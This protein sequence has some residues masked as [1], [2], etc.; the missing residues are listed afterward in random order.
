M[1]GVCLVVC[2]VVG[3]VIVTVVVRGDFYGRC[4]RNIAN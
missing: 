2:L 3:V 4:W 1:T